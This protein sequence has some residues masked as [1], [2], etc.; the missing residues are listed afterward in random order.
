MTLPTKE[1]F[2][3]TIQL[4]LWFSVFSLQNTNRCISSIVYENPTTLS[5]VQRF[6]MAVIKNAWFF[7]HLYSTYCKL[8]AHMFTP[9]FTVL[10]IMAASQATR[11]IPDTGVTFITFFTHEEFSISDI[12]EFFTLLGGHCLYNSSL[13]TNFP[14]IGAEL[15]T[16]SCKRDLIFKLPSDWQNPDPGRKIHPVDFL[17]L[18]KLCLASFLS[19]SNIACI[20]SQ[21]EYFIN[22]LWNSDFRFSPEPSSSIYFFCL[23]NLDIGHKLIPMTK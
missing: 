18:P 10:R 15:M 23:P 22:L 8:H 9:S 7:Q 11:S 20:G 12:C 13:L 5:L 19:L 17:F 16:A 14:I 4:F 2:K 6:V 21:Q 3:G 1:F